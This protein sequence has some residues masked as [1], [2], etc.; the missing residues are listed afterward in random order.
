MRHLHP[1]RAALLLALLW[2]AAPLQGQGDLPAVHVI[3]T[4]GTI[5]NTGTAARLTGEDLVQSL[6][7]VEKVATLTIE[8]FS[9]LPSGSI[10]PE[11]WRTLAQRIDALF[12]ERP[13]LRGVVVTHGTDTAE[14]TAY[15]LDL[16]VA[17]CRPVM[18]TGAMRRA[19]DVGADGPANLLNSIRVAV[20][21][22][23]EG[24][25]TLLLLN[26]EIFAA[27]EVAKLH[28]SRMDA[29]AAP[30]AGPLGVADPDTVVFRRAPDRRSCPAAAFPSDQLGE[31]P[32]VDIV[33][34]YAGADSVAIEAAIQA[35]ALG[36]VL[37]SVGRGGMTPAQGR[38]LR[39]A[40][41]QGV[42]VVLSSRTGGGRVPVDRSETPAQWRGAILG[43]GDLNPQKARVLLMLALSR[44]RDPGEVR[45]IIR[46]Q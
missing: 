41:E 26:D 8:Q 4:G 36:I 20:A 2:S 11:H 10:T 17:S 22:A 39:R 42:F 28:T 29:F 44:T 5:S 37:A 6:P 25:G 30:E 9:N 15:F 23:A 43:A 3:A 34:S 31:L 12:R 45:E 35:G 40:A 32:R 7:G 13:E 19:T 18:V 16:T 1:L 38:A 21:P 33:Y 27:R 14:E 46:S 24:R